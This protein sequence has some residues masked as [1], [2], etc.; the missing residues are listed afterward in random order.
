MAKNEPP[1]NARNATVGIAEGHAI[2]RA[3]LRDVNG[4]NVSVTGSKLAE[5]KS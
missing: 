4:H 5:I 1:S 3:P 2:G